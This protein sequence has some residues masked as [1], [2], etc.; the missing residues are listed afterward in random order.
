MKLRDLRPCDWCGKQLAGRMPDGRLSIQFYVVTLA[1]AIL[2]TQAINEHMGLAM[3]LGGS[4]QL[5]EV[6]TSHP[7]VAAIV[8]DQPGAG[9]RAQAL[10]CF[11]CY[12]GGGDRGLNLA[13]LAERLQERKKGPAE[14]GTE[15]A[16]VKA[17]RRRRVR[18]AGVDEASS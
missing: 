6:F 18:D 17:G 12:A 1:T 9:G 5:A 7:D 16:K 14:T 3:M 11:D 10:L 13:A 2:N 15:A 8:E 4:H